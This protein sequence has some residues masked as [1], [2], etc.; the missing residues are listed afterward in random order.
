VKYSVY[1]RKSM[2]LNGS[3]TVAVHGDEILRDQLGV[4]V[5]AKSSSHFVPWDN[6]AYTREER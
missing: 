4:T 5:T 6:V 1:L 3:K 2:T